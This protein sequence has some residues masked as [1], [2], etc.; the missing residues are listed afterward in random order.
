M[1]SRGPYR[2]HSTPF[3]LQLC[4]DIRS[5]IIGRCDAQRTRTRPLYSP[6]LAL[7][8][9]AVVSIHFRATGMGTAWW[10]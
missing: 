4:H 5:G 6:T 10:P 8:H 7:I 3:K 1:T 9:S 2:R